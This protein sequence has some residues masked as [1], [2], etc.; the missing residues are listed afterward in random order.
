MLLSNDTLD[1]MLI[2]LEKAY[3]EWKAPVVTFVAETTA[4]DDASLPFRV[5]IATLLSLRTK[6]QTTGAAF[7]RL[8]E[9]AE[10]APASVQALGEQSIAGLIYPVGFYKV[11][12]GR[13]MEI[14]RILLE[15]Y[16]GSVPDTLEALLELPGV[17]RKTANLVV[18]LG[19]GKPA[20]C[21]DIHVHRISNRWGYISTPNPDKSEMALREKLPHRWWNRYNDLLVAFG[22]TICRPL[23]PL[24]SQCPVEGTCAKRGVTHSR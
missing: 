15:R 21:V 6:D 5:L 4:G 3:T 17:G 16:E 7:A 13:I 1:A 10:A 18:A 19:F 12:A 22:Q 11:K 24:C 14:C 9:A 20:M 2:T 8:F 23:S